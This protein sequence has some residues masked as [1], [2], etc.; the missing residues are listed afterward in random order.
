MKKWLKYNSQ[1]FKTWFVY[2]LLKKKLSNKAIE[3][4]KD[5]YNFKPREKKLFERIIK[6]Q[7]GNK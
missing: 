6:I 7:G 4:M 3:L 5:N 1:I 2:I